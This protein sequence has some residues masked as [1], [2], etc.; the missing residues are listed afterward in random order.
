[1]VAFTILS[2]TKKKS[3]GHSVV[4]PWT[5]SVVVGALF[6]PRAYIHPLASWLYLSGTSRCS[7]ML[8]GLRQ[9]GWRWFL[10]TAWS[11]GLRSFWDRSE[12]WEWNSW[13][14]ELDWDFTESDCWSGLQDGSQ[15]HP[16]L[17]VSI[18]L[19]IPLQAWVVRKGTTSGNRKGEGDAVALSHSKHPGLYG[20]TLKWGY[21]IA[22]WFISWKGP[23]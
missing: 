15:A 6:R 20:G 14:L 4:V 13:W 3:S 2:D 7:E 12:I 9:K 21:T 5:G 23:K 8:R 1:M 11:I 10:G 19:P 16:C 17:A 18:S 22:G